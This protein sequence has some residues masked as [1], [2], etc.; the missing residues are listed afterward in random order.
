MWLITPRIGFSVLSVT[1]SGVPLVPHPASLRCTCNAHIMHDIIWKA[2]A[3][4]V[5]G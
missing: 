1:L 4:H 2:S 3:M 5:H